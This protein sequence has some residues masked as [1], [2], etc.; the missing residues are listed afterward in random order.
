MSQAKSWFKKAENLLLEELDELRE[1]KPESDTGVPTVATKGFANIELLAESRLD[2]PEEEW[3]ELPLGQSAIEYYCETTR[4][5]SLKSI[6]TVNKKVDELE[7][8]I[9]KSLGDTKCSTC[10]ETYLKMKT[11]KKVVIRMIRDGRTNEDI[12]SIFEDF[13]T[14]LL[15]HLRKQVENE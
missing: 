7:E 14:S 4:N 15:K 9:K 1:Q 13:P 10:D 6:Q 3:I 8:E 5:N 12:K 11:D 2:L